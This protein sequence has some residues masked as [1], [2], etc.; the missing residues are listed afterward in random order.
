MLTAQITSEPMPVGIAIAVNALFIG[1]GVYLL[2]TGFHPAWRRPVHWGRMKR[3]PILSRWSHIIAGVFVILAPFGIT[4]EAFGF[5]GALA[6][7]CGVIAGITSAALIGAM[8]YD[9]I[10]H[11]R[12]PTAS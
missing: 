12:T 5:S 3:G 4:G 7:T 11:K 2:L 6:T 9:C 1:V 8:I 10:I